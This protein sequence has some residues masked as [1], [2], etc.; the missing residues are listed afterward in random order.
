MNVKFVDRQ[1]GDHIVIHIVVPNQFNAVYHHGIYIADDQVIHVDGPKSIGTTTLQGFAGQHSVDEIQEVI[2]PTQFSGS[3]IVERAKS[4]LG[5]KVFFNYN[6]AYS[7]C[8]HFAYY[9][10]TDKW[11]SKQIDNI[12]A[13]Y[14][15]L[16]RNST[17]PPE[18]Q[19]VRM[20]FT[21]AGMRS[22][23]WRAKIS[24]GIGLIF[25]KGLDWVHDNLSESEKQAEAYADISTADI[26]TGGKNI[27]L[28]HINEQI[29][30][31]QLG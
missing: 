12:N 2:Y 22:G 23:N 1:P 8:E 9:C 27:P 18:A 21:S 6:L 24:F 15:L 30:R 28:A 10:R 29:R 20:A 3:E 7:N 31:N 17:V 19:I 5:N 13:L 4:L 11:D 16:D 25:I 14:D 26:S